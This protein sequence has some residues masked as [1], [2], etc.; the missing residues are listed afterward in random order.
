VDFQDVGDIWDGDDDDN[1]GGASPFV[2]G[3]DWGAP[4][5]ADEEADG[6][7]EQPRRVE[8]VDVNYARYV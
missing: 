1:G 4:D 5:G 8:K 3:A 2:G 6:L 7:V